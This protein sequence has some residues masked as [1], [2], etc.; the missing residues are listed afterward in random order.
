[1]KIENKKELQQVAFNHSWDID[2]EESINIYKKYTAE[3]CFFLVIDTALRL[4]HHLRFRYN[5]LENIW[6]F[7]IIIDDKIRYEKLQFDINREAAN[8][9]RLSSGKINKYEYLTGEEILPSVQS[10]MID[11]AKFTYSLGKAFEKQK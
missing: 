10:Q 1:M 11:W 4:R 2:I 3:P 8:I 5:L 6:K 7:I 9:Y